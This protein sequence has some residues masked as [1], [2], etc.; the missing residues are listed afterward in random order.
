MFRIVVF[1]GTRPEAIKLAPV[2]AALKRDAGIKPIVINTGQHCELIRQV[3]ELFGIQIEQDLAVMTE[4]QGLTLLLARLLEQIDSTLVNLRPHMVLAQGDTSTVLAAALATF[5]RQIPFG[6]VEAGFRTGNMRSPFPEEANRVLVSRLTDLHF[7]PTKMAA[8][9][10]TQEGI[11]EQY[12]VVTGNTVVDALFM[13]LKRQE[14]NVIQQSIRQSL[15]N[16]VGTDFGSRPFVLV[17]AHRR[18]NFGPGFEHICSAIHEL[19]ARFPHHLFIYPVHLNPNVQEVV[20]RRL[21]A[22]ENVR[23][24]EPQPYGEFVSLLAG[25]QL[26][27]TDSGGVQEE[28]PSLGKPV[29]LMRDTTERHEGIVTRTVKLVSTNKATIVEEASSL[30]SNANSYPS[31]VVDNPYGDGKAAHRIVIAIQDF[32]HRKPPKFT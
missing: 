18:E 26:V 15:R 6:H 17:T 32:F 21:G 27:L 9:N 8:D 16:S 7:A 11:S 3:I 13:E 10:L 1:M 12:I 25:C 14:N 4:N 24:I 19:A 5:N 30:L 29:L 22:T 20:R 23:L 2:V 28:A 31:S